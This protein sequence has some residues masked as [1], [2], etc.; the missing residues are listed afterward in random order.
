MIMT[1]SLDQEDLKLLLM[2]ALHGMPTLLANAVTRDSRQARMESIIGRLVIASAKPEEPSQDASTECDMAVGPCSCGAWHGEGK[3]KAKVYNPISDGILRKEKSGDDS[4]GVEY[5]YEV[6]CMPFSC[7]VGV[8]PSKFIGQFDSLDR[9]KDE[10]VKNSMKLG[11]TTS[12]GV[13]VFEIRNG[14]IIGL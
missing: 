2:A 13:C 1:I 8:P 9:A 6:Y 10:W 4:G 14:K 3:P 5:V 7:G 11:R 12:T